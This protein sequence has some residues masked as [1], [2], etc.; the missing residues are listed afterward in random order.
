M[1]YGT[2]AIFG[3]PA[4]DQRDL[5]F[6]RKYGLPVKPVVLPPD[7]D[8]ADLRGRRRGLYRRRHRSINSDFL[9]GLDVEDGQAPRPSPRSSGEG[10]GKRRDHYRLRDWGVSRQ[11]YWGCPIPVIHCDACGVVPVPRRPAA[12]RAARRRRLLDGPA[13][14][15]MRH[16]TWKHVDLPDLRRRG[17]SARPTRSTPSSIAP[18]TSRAS[19]TP[20]GRPAVRPRR[21][22][23]LAAGRPVYRRRRARGPAPALRPLLHPRAA[24]HR[25]ARRSTSRSPAC[26]RRAWS[27]TRPIEAEDGNWLEP[28]EVEA[29][30]RRLGAP[31]TAASPVDARPRREDV[32]VEEERRRPRRRSSTHYGADAARWFVLSDSPPER[33]LEWTDC[34]RRRRLALPGPPVAAGGR[35]APGWPRCSR[36]GEL[37]PRP[38]H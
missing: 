19:P 25:P 18:G 23:L 34:R 3:C 4:H 37:G 17:A 10:W 22:R 6:A 13:I 7:A 31:S 9:D 33:D 35:A 5:D 24:R 32:E 30:G 8:P 11:R 38:E 29:R 14:R 26:S 12:G 2:G 28:D 1:D 15:S 16:P 27:R 20:A 36:G 21:R